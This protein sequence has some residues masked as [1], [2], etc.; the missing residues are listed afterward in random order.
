MV[1][2][3]DDQSWDFAVEKLI[4]LT[5]GGQLQW[6]EAKLPLRPLMQD[7]VGPQYMAEVEGRHIAVYEYAF[8]TESDEYGKFTSS[9]IRI[10][11]VTPAGDPVWVWPVSK[12]RRQLLDAVRK[13]G[14]EANQFL[15][16]FLADRV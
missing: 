11:F 5:E 9:M 1:D 14:T 2:P 16:A 3:T 15:E 6:H 12:G 13:Q 7:F 4:R 8:P 10:E